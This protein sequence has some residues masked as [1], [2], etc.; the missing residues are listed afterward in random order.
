M[1][2]LHIPADDLRIGDIIIHNDGETAVRA[3]DRSAAPT[4]V[5]NPGDTDQ[6][7]GYLWQHVTVR[8][9]TQ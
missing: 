6:I 3:L 5:T 2:D 1:T 8:R 7:S 9:Q 4:I